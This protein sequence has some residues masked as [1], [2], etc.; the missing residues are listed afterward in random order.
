MYICLGE[1]IDKFWP[2]LVMHIKSIGF[3]F[4]VRGLELDKRNALIRDFL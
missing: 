2:F 3:I 1:N 4:G